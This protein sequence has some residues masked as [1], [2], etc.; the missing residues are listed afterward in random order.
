M[1]KMKKK[2]K[3]FYYR[4]QKINN[5]QIEIIFQFEQFILMEDG[6]KNEK[7]FI[8]FQISFDWNQG[9]IASVWCWWFGF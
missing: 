5:G 9:E 8:A 4:L 1:V 3:Q 7:K 6:G 2:K